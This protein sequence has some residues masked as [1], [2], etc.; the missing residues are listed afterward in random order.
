MQRRRQL[1]ALAETI[2]V[3][4]KRIQYAEARPGINGI[5]EL[6]IGFYPTDEVEAYAA[7]SYTQGDRFLVAPKMWNNDNNRYA[8]LGK[9][10]DVWGCAF[11]SSTTGGTA[12][13]PAVEPDMLFHKFAYKD[14][15]FRSD[16]IGISRDVGHISFG[17][18][19]ANINLFYGYNS[20]SPGKIS[21]YRH[22]KANGISV[23]IIPI[24]D[25]TTG[26]VEMYDTVSKTIMPRTGTL[27]P[28]EE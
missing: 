12:F 22:K 6:P 20:F 2:P 19:T 8:L 5:V 21:Y 16:D 18:E 1:M 14:F 11:G 9:Y 17:S 4:Y 3:G 10:Y 28:P 7:I 26:V 15:V 13:S 23:N 27:Y 24:Q 25:K